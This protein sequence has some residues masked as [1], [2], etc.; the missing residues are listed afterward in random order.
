MSRERAE[1]RA[2]EFGPNELPKPSRPHILLRFLSHFH[3]ILIYVLLG[4][5]VITSLLGHFVDT[6][7]IAAVVVIN[8]LIGF[9]QEGKA[10]KA[11]DAIK[12]MLAL[13]ADVIREG[14]RQN[15]KAEALVPGD[16]V[17]LEAGNKV[18][19]DLRLLTTHGLH[20]QE[21][22]LTGE[23]IPVQKRIEA[24]EAD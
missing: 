15:I 2:L 18:P 9:I 24:V 16:I 22:I 13:R 5:A 4:A 1:E 20:I 7:V 12:D 19:A 17:L 21:A 23:A 10:E 11:M 8:A 3:N 6:A 14:K